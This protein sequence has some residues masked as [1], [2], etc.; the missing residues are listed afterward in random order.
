MRTWIAL[1]LA[2]SGCGASPEEQC[3]EAAATSCKKLFECWTTAD[4]R[5]RLMLGADAEACTQSASVRCEAPA[6]LCAAPHVWDAA[7]ASQCTSEFAA[8]TCS[9]LRSGAT[10]PSCSNTCK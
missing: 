8:L 1:V 3:R 4:D 7:A 2:L 6:V 9:A 10:P 5:A